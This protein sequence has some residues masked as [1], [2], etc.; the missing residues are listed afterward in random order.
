MKFISDIVFGSNG[1]AVND[2]MLQMVLRG[3]LR[4]KTVEHLPP[5]LVTLFTPSGSHANDTVEGVEFQFFAQGVVN[6]VFLYSSR[7]PVTCS[8]R[9]VG[10]VWTENIPA[11]SPC[12]QIHHCGPRSGHET[13]T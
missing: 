13:L 12:I 1:W 5:R 11:I 8:R 7:R 10:N 3:T 2:M 9:V 6:Y 4:K